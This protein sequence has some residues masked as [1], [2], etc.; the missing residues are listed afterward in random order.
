MIDTKEYLKHTV[1]QRACEETI[2]KFDFDMMKSILNNLLVDEFD[3][4]LEDRLSLSFCKWQ[5]AIS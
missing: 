5:Q 2:L 4:R 3:Y 1:T